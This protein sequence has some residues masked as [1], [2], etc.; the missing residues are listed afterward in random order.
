MSAQTNYS[1]GPKR[2]SG[3]LRLIIY[4][5]GARDRQLFFK[6]FFTCYRFLCLTPHVFFIKNTHTSVQYVF[7]CRTSPTRPED[8]VYRTG[9]GMSRTKCKRLGRYVPTKRCRIRRDLMAHDPKKSYLYV[10]RCY[11]VS[12]QISTVV[13]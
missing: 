4:D 11:I 8:N 2:K 13:G 9:G 6:N 7:R 5:S 3:L 1:V 12:L 10:N